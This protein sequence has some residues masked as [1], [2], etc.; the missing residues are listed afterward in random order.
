VFLHDIATHASRKLSGV[1]KQPPQRVVF[2][3]HARHRLFAQSGVLRKSESTCDIRTRSRF[4][5]C[6]GKN[7][8]LSISKEYSSHGLRLPLRRLRRR[9][10]E[11]ERNCVTLWT[12]FFLRSVYTFAAGTQ[13]RRCLFETFLLLNGDVNTNTDIILIIVFEGVVHVEKKTAKNNR[14]KNEQRDD[15]GAHDERYGC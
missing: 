14:E 9:E 15:V 8:N 3:D 5:P 11:K 1:S 6:K 4:F 7:Q 12:F 13:N 2:L 10:K